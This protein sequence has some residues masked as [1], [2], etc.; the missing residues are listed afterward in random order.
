MTLGKIHKIPCNPSDMRS[1]TV[2]TAATA[3][4]A[5]ATTIKVSCSDIFHLW[6]GNDMLLEAWGPQLCTTAP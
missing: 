6:D 2:T 1:L 3:I 5:V 4:A